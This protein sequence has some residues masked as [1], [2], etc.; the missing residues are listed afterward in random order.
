MMINTDYV[1]DYPR[2]LP[3]SF[4][5]IGGIQIKEQA[6]LLPPA[7]GD[8]VAGADAGVILFTMGFIFNPATVPLER[9]QTF[10]AAFGRLQQKV[11]FKFDVTGLPRRGAELAVPPNVLMQDWLPQADILAHANTELFITHC[12][13]HGVL[14]A[15]H[16]G[17]PM[18]GV[19]IFIDQGDVLTRMLEKGIAVGLDKYSSE[20][21]ILDAVHE[22]LANK[23]YKNNVMKL[24]SLMRLRKTGSM[25]AAISLLTHVAETKG[26]EYLKVDSRFLN[27]FQY[28]CIDCILV[29]LFSLA[30]LIFIVF[31]ATVTIKYLVGFLLNL[32]KRIR[33]TLFIVFKITF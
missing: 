20:T 21:E 18:V 3:P 12:G 31:L 2:P 7:L 8:F 26:A 1:L 6:G 30:V 16:F 29:L 23:Q 15:I 33:Y 11:V 32:H 4:I 13:M 27:I 14:E 24:S 17:V 28:Y 10:L 19:P 25:D 5:N 9:I 22:V